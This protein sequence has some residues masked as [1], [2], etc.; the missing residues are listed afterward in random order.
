[1][2]P[3]ANDFPSHLLQLLTGNLVARNIL[4]YFREPII[5]IGFRFNKTYRALVPKASINENDNLLGSE[6]NIRLAGKVLN[7]YP[8][9]PPASSP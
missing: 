3:Y 4:S 1:M 2:L 6:H 5:S 8:V 9:S 7:I